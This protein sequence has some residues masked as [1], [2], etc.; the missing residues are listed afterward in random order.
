MLGAV[1]AAVGAQELNSLVIN[2]FAGV[3]L[4]SSPSNVAPS[5]SPD[6][7]NMVRDSPGK[8]RKRMGYALHS[9]YAGAVNGFYSLVGA[10]QTRRFI[11]AGTQLYELGGSESIAAGLADAFSS[12]RQIGDSL[13]ISDGVKLRRFDGE[14]LTDVQNEAYV[15]TVII[16]RSPSGG[17][18]AYEPLNLLGAQ[19]RE[20]FLS[21][22]VSA[23]YQLSY[24][25]LDSAAEVSVRVMT[26][27]N[28]WS[29][30]T[31][32]TD[33]T[34][35][36]QTGTVSFV[37]AVAASPV[38][39]MDNVVITAK[40]TRESYTAQINRCCF[41]ALFGVNGSADRLFVSGNA[42]MPNC[43]WYSQLNEPLYF[44]EYNRTALGQDSCEIAGYTLV[45]NKLA[46]HKLHDDDDR[47][48][49]LRSGEMID[50]EAAFPIVNTLVGPPCA[51]RWA[52]AQTDEE[53]LYFTFQG[54]YAITAQDITGERCTQ[55]RTYYINSAL[56]AESSPETACAC[57][58]ADYYVL[59][60]GG[61]L[62]LAD[63]LVKEYSENQPHSKF[64]YECY[65]C[66]DIPA[67]RVW[68]WDKQLYFGTADG[69]V[70]RFYSDPDSLSSYNDC[71]AAVSAYWTL[72]DFAGKRFYTKKSFRAIAMKL[73]SAPSTSVSIYAKI[74][75]LWTL[76]SENDN[77][78][79]YFQFSNITFSKLSFSCDTTPRTLY[80]K[81][82]IKRVPS[83]Q[84]K[85]QNDCLNEPF[86]I[87]EVGLEYSESG[88]C[89]G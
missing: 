70:M 88:H 41:G 23:V 20:S 45:D 83:A 80:K 63:T 26:A 21:D 64:Q 78:A 30:Y 36:A 54:V 42:D 10:G 5:R 52:F 76:L 75:G 44:P 1:S 14:T 29:D 34:V 18:S 3:D 74:R 7:P 72:P 82:S 84:F 49:V 53:P 4:H 61:K 56:A 47:N 8:V 55:N 12:G 32:G 6:A 17:G 46:A 25:Q 38:T 60:L 89:K 40:K 86:G 33:F 31:N 59:A 39:G 71:G 22:G 28:V 77:S 48:I 16:G 19:W 67:Q 73:M 87:Y 68:E 24:A 66:T 2:R 69:K 51:S 15:P 11:H 9:Q 35:N 65:V 27:E 79:R 37:S 43:D 58:H 57:L 50:G 81:L 85:L 13:Y 62:Y